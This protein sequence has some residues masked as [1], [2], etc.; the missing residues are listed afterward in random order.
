MSRLLQL[1]ILVHQARPDHLKTAKDRKKLPKAAKTAKCKAA[2]ECQVGRQSTW[3]TIWIT[4]RYHSTRLRLI[5]QSGGLPPKEWREST[6]DH[7]TDHQLT[8]HTQTLRSRRL[9]S[10]QHRQY[11]NSMLHLEKLENSGDSEKLTRSP[12]T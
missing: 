3:I 12:S 1:P 11:R 10:W 4:S 5:A 2:P 8:H 6:L 9:L 7:H